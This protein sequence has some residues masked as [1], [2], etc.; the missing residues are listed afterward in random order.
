MY[1]H[2][3]SLLLVTPSDLLQEDSVLRFVRS[4]SFEPQPIDRELRVVIEVESRWDATRR[5]SS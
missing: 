3:N 5:W 4:L 2:D 1:E